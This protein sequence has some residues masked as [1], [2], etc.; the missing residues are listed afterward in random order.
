MN[1]ELLKAVDLSAQNAGEEQGRD[2]LNQL[3]GQAQMA[4]AIGMCK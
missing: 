3:L 1:N 2:L 4:G